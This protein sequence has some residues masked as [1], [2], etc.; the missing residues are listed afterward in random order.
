MVIDYDRPQNQPQRFK[1]LAEL[2]AATGQET[3]GIEVDYDIFES[4][5]A[6]VPPDSS[7]PGS[8]WWS[9]ARRVAPPHCP[10]VPFSGFR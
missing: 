5:R 1:T 6:P 3:H 4:L 8:S 9:I 2:A 7:K 10:N